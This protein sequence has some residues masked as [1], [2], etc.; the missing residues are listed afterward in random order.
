MVLHPIQSN[1]VFQSEYTQALPVQ[2]QRVKELIFLGTGTSS[3]LPNLF[4]LVDTPGASRREGCET[5]L[6][7]LNGFQDGLI[8]KN[9]RRNTSLLVRYTCVDG[10]SERN[11]GHGQDSKDDP[12]RCKNENNE[13]ALI[14]LDRDAYLDAQPKDLFTRGNTLDDARRQSSRETRST[15]CDRLVNVVIDCGKVGLWRQVARIS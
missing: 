12:T 7:A 15:F 6:S 10:A 4:C 3:S 9:R 13:P 2:G 5:C 14:M 1:P 11:R 8:S